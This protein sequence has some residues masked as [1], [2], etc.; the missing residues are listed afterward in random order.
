MKINWKQ[1]APY[2]LIGLVFVVAAMVYFFPSLQGKIIYA[3]DSINAQAAVHESAEY[4]KAGGNTF[5][6]GAMFSGMPNYQIGGGRTLTSKIL[7]PIRRLTHLGP[8]VSFFIFLF[9]LIAFFAL[10]RTFGIDKWLSM[11]GA[12]AIAMSSYFF[13]IIAAQHGRFSRTFRC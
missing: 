9:Y 13:V 12:F 11:A 4:G 3:G 10:L 1:I 5:W 6:T 2:A 7:T 8:K